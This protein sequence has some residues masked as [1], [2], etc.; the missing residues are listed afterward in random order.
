MSFLQNIKRR[1]HWYGYPP[2]S[3][4]HS[5]VVTMFVKMG[6]RDVSFTSHLNGADF[7]STICGGYTKRT[8]ESVEEEMLMMFLKRIGA[9]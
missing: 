3:P 6:N 4:L 9:T 1:Y 5:V 8:K 2:E 7:L